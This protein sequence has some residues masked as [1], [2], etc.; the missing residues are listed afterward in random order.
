MRK[1][2]DQRFRKENKAPNPIPHVMIILTIRI[3]HVMI[4]VTSIL[5]ENATYPNKRE[6][7]I[8]ALKIKFTSKLI[9]QAVDFKGQNFF[10]SNI[11]Y[12]RATF[13]TN[14]IIKLTNHIKKQRRERGFTE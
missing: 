12:K 3:P 11:T 10:L 5:P 1:S 9:D 4:S 13:A 14:W 7:N 6:C 2:R 8:I